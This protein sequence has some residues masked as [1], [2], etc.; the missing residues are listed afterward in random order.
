MYGAMRRHAKE[1]NDFFC[2]DPV[3]QIFA[4]RRA[5]WMILCR[6]LYIVSSSLAYQ[7][8]AM[9]IW[10]LLKSVIQWQSF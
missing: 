7:G 4:A 1:L 5:V 8:T 2:T 6:C 3:E 10:D 9:K